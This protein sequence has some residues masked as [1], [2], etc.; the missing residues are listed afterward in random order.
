LDIL[1]NK[2]EEK[3]KQNIPGLIIFGKADVYAIE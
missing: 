1:L 2:N 3:D